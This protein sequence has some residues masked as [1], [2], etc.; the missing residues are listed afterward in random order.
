MLKY[1]LFIIIFFP[2]FA[3]AQTGSTGSL[4]LLLIGIGGF[5][6]N[7][8]I[9]FILA[10]AFIV[11]VVNVVR[12]FIIGGASEEGQ[13]NAKNLAIYGIG[14]FVFI[15]SFWGLVNMVVS[16]VGLAKDPCYPVSD[17]VIYQYGKRLGVSNR[18]GEVCPAP[19]GAIVSPIP[20][21]TTPQ[22]GE[23]TPSLG[24]PVDPP[25]NTYPLS[26]PIQ[27]PID[28]TSPTSLNPPPLLTPAE[29][30]R[31]MMMMFEDE[32]RTESKNYFDS[33]PVKYGANTPIIMASLFADLATSHSDTVTN[34][35]RAIAAARLTRAGIISLDTLNDY[36]NSINNYN[37]SEGILERFNTEYFLREADRVPSIPIEIIANMDN[38]A[39][40]IRDYL[41]EYNQE[42]TGAKVDEELFNKNVSVETRL[43]NFQR[44][45]V[46]DKKDYNDT[47]I[48]GYDLYIFIQDLNTELLYKG[49]YKTLD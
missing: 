3:I 28:Y 5:L 9:P 17:Y 48:I 20:P 15:L 35:E 2:V 38:T 39:K 46:A 19:S 10:I 23:E 18:S 47:Y 41:F 42:N 22:S 24:T 31:H 30:S 14:A 43:N 11:F 8:V 26:Q 6:N 40:T 12:F 27:P 49:D 29:A 32:I 36:V 4:Q 7:I 33:F 16:G 44:Y 25:L 34:K 21:I 1:A 37:S 45:F 13:K